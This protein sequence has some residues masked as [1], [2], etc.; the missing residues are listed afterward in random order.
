MVESQL[1]TSGVNAEWVLRRM[2]EVAREDYVPA[3]RRNVA[4]M[5]RAVQLDGGGWLAGPV[6]HGLMLQEAR[7]HHADRVLLVD[8]GSGYLA[9]LLRP[10]VASVQ[11]LDVATATA[12]TVPGDGYTLLLVD[13]AAEVL[14]PALLAALAPDGRIVTGLVQDGVTRIAAG[15]VVEGAAALLPLAEIGMPVLPAFAAPKTWSF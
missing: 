1:R 12:G 11:V 3:N 2:G 4:Y 7:P 13:G 5:D 9:D 14:P 8:G 15:R 6:V 10:A